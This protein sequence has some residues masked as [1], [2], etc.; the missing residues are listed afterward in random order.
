MTWLTGTDGL[1][2]YFNK[3]WL[4]FTRRGMEQ[5]VGTGCIEGVHRDDVQGCFDGF[6]PAFHARKPFRMQ[7]RLRQADGEYRW[8]IESG[9]PRYARGEFAGY[10]GSNM[11]VLVRRDLLERS[12]CHA[13]Q[14]F[15][16]G[17]HRN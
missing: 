2:N 10:I 5:E 12:H 6:L 14:C 15:F 17:N 13:P 16:V 4:E 7:Y 8:V 9:I 3:P 11:H 1:C